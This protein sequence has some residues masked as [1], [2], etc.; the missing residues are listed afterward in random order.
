VF[1]LNGGGGACLLKEKVTEEGK[2][3]YH[4]LFIRN[5]F[6]TMSQPYFR[7]K[8]VD[9]GIRTCAHLDTTAFFFYTICS[10]IKMVFRGIE[11][12][13]HMTEQYS[14]INPLKTKSICSI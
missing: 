9:F 12:V 11:Q 14:A 5:I 3:G 4:G 13:Q 6:Q 7:L 2:G 1:G 10:K 8:V